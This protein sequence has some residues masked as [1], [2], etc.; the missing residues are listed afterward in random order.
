MANYFQEATQKYVWEDLVLLYC[1]H[2][3]TPTLLLQYPFEDI[4]MGGLAMVMD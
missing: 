3:S 2:F 4:E 1:S